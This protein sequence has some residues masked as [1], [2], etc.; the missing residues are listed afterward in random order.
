MSRSDKHLL[1]N[2]NRT[3]KRARHCISSSSSSSSSSLHVSCPVGLMAMKNYPPAT[4]LVPLS[5]SRGNPIL[6]NLLWHL[7]CRTIDLL[8]A[9]CADFRQKGWGRFFPQ[10]RPSDPA[11]FVEKICL[12]RTC[13]CVCVAA[14][15]WFLSEN[16][17]LR[18]L[19]FREF[20]A[21]HAYQSRRKGV[22]VL[23]RWHFR[24]LNR[25]EKKNWGGLTLKYIHT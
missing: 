2:I 8:H 20:W 22:W 12:G 23:L 3:L 14:L 7:L 19:F 9:D 21:G 5:H 10:S 15:S 4:S 16:F 1:K 24:I 6:S 25:M 11:L 18:S 13:A 17:M